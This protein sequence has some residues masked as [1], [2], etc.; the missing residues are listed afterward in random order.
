MSNTEVITDS[1]DLDAV[2]STN[3]RYRLSAEGGNLYKTIRSD[4]S[5]KRHGK[6]TGE[7]KDA[8]FK[9]TRDDIEEDDTQKKSTS[10]RVSR[11]KR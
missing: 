11:F 4:G 3:F 6:S 7:E 10:G 9:E 2:H 5:I 8:D 1:K